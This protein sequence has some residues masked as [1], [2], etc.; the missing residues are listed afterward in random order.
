MLMCADFLKARAAAPQGIW[1]LIMLIS[2]Y[3]T[4]GTAQARHG[5]DASVQNHKLCDKLFL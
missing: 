3:S 4:F 5:F 2:V 1:T